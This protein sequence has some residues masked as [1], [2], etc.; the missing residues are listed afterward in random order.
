MYT[1]PEQAVL[2]QLAY[3]ISQE[4]NKQVQAFA[5]KTMKMLA[6]SQNPVHEQL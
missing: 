6:N 3:T 2:D 5:Y 1:L 4:P